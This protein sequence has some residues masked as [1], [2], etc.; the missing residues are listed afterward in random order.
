LFHSASWQPN[1]FRSHLL[2]VLGLGHSVIAHSISSLSWTWQQKCVLEGS[3]ELQHRLKPGSVA[4]HM[5]FGKQARAD[6]VN[7]VQQ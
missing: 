1:K 6:G 3:H 7:E 2:C 5:R 4:A